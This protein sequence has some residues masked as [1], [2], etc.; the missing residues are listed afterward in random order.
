VVIF[1]HGIRQMRI[2]RDPAAVL[3]DVLRGE[4]AI[5]L[6][7][8]LNATA[9]EKMTLE[10]VQEGASLRFEDLAQHILVNIPMDFKTLRPAGYD[11]ST[12][13]NQLLYK[14]AVTGARQA[15]VE[16][17]DLE[18]KTVKQRQE[19]KRVEER[20]IDRTL[21]SDF[22][23][24]IEPTYVVKIRNEDGSYL[25]TTGAE[26]KGKKLILKR[27]TERCAICR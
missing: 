19:W 2:E 11:L 14:M 16:L 9:N 12:P 13:D 18:K 26:L 17:L 5:A 27:A 20:S 10:S 21:A 23:W 22:T 3:A 6:Q 7:P 4:V 15:V 24:R 1:E 8:Y 25:E